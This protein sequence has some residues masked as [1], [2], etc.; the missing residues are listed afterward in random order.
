MFGNV[1]IAVSLSEP[2][3]ILICDCMNVSSPLLSSD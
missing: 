1:L 2:N 3:C